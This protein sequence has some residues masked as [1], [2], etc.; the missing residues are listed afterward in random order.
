[1][2]DSSTKGKSGKLSF[3]EKTTKKR[4]ELTQKER[5]DGKWKRRTEKKTVKKMR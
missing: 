4:G 3:E 1:M 2:M 5:C